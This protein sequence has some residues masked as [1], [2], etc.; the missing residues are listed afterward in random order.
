MLYKAHKRTRSVV[1]RG[2]RQWKRR[3]HILHAEIRVKSPAYVCRIIEVCAML[4]NICKDPCFL[5]DEESRKLTR[6]TRPHTHKLYPVPPDG[7]KVCVTGMPMSTFTLSK[8][9]SI[10][11]CMFIH[12]TY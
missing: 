5:D 8:C 1:E 10:Q 12:S 4:Y 2:I 3:F 6:L 9:Y 7:R 11:T